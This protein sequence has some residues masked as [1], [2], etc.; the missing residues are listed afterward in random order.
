MYAPAL[1]LG[2]EKTKDGK[3]LNGTKVSEKELPGE[4]KVFLIQVGEITAQVV[5]SA[6]FYY[7]VLVLPYR[8]LYF[9]PFLVLYL[10]FQE[11]FL[12]CCA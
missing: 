11:T 4:L 7:S 6:T 9:T 3:I 8:N 12:E 10:C 2:L 5:N 1:V